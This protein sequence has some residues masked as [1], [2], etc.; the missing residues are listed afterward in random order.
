MAL[1]VF[2]CKPDKEN[3]EQSSFNFECFYLERERAT[4]RETKCKDGKKKQK[5]KLERER[6]RKSEHGRILLQQ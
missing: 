6:E 1:G 4:R 5:T 2:V 3:I